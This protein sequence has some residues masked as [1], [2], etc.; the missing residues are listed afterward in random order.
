MDPATSTAQGED[1]QARLTLQ[2]FLRALRRDWW[3]VVA[4]TV[5]V[6][7]AAGLV[8]MAQKPV[9]QSGV[10][11]LFREA[12]SGAGMMG[13]LD[14]RMALPVGS[15]GLD[16]DILVLRSRQIAEDVANSLALHIEVVEPEVSRRILFDAIE[17]GS[18]AVA[19]TY[20]LARLDGGAFQ[21]TTPTGIVHPLQLRAGAP[22]G[23][24]GLMLVPSAAL[25]DGG[26]A[27]VRFMVRDPQ[28][29]VGQLRRRVRVNRVDGRATVVSIDYRHADP[30]LAARIPNAY[31]ERFIDFKERMARMESGTSVAFLREQ[32]EASEQQ[33]FRSE[34]RLR[35]F[36]QVNQVVNLEE[37]AKEQIARLIQLQVTRDQVGAELAALSNLL[38]QA[39]AGDFG[40]IS[41]YRQLAS[42]P[43]FLINKAVQDLLASLMELENRRSELL[44]LR[45]P[46]NLDVRAV[47]QRIEELEMQLYQ[48]ARNY[49]TSLSNQMVS[50]DTSIADFQGELAN[51]PEKE[52]QFAR[53]ARER[54][55]LA[56]MYMLLQRRLQEAEIQNAAT[57]SD[58]RVLDV[59]LTPGAPVSP[60]PLINLLFGFVVGMLLGTGTVLLRS[61]LDR[62]VHS[63]VEAREAAIRLPVLGIIPRINA[64][65]ERPRER[66][67][68]NGN[69]RQRKLPLALRT[70]G[71]SF[72]STRNL[73]MLESPNSPAA[74]AFRGIPDSFSA[75]AQD[76]EVGS[77]VVT[78][79]LPGD[80]KSTA[81]ANLALAF[82]EQGFRTLLVDADLRRGRVHKLFGLPASP[83]LWDVLRGTESLADAIHRPPVN[84]GVPELSVLPAGEGGPDL[85]AARYARRVPALIDE[86]RG[87]F[88]MIVFDAPPIGL[89]P[90]ASSLA[91]QADGIILVARVGSTPRDRLM[92]AVQ[93]V[94]QL[95]TPVRGL[96]L[97][98][99][100]LPEHDERMYA[101]YA[102]AQRT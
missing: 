45:T 43:S 102:A 4:V 93:Q 27:I 28:G 82:S 94:E 36:S 25:A 1:L 37:E 80:G 87:D 89:F 7:L 55:M 21:L 91:T 49:R 51:V 52:L 54:E 3:L 69:G 31:A 99:V 70:I 53:L 92:Q 90:D 100:P 20:R 95:R 66:A 57:P 58:V 88:D 12:P 32:V 8:T 61:Q 18:G 33:L 41:P 67:L 30:V 46:E 17:A 39:E 35:D 5:V 14:P 73:V 60:N 48:L 15:L 65:G 50:L 42:F 34:E 64:T 83:G 62:T 77:L 22:V 85:G 38:E 26:Y 56:E 23:V 63:P 13:Q 40:G 98:D 84:G 29:V 68:A 59:A 11:L 16:S 96:L 79:V 74:D 19:G 24:A 76:D 72:P 44:V 10:T 75:L 6:T 47:D 86:V 101:E 81:A 78:S 9:Y 71:T 97:N 2:R